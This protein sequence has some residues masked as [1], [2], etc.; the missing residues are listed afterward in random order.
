MHF[1]HRIINT[2][3]LKMSSK[4]FY[5]SN[6][7]LYISSYKKSNIRTLAEH[8]I[9]DVTE[10]N[11]Y[12]HKS[13]QLRLQTL[14]YILVCMLSS[15][16]IKKI[17][18]A[19]ATAFVADVVFSGMMRNSRVMCFTYFYRAHVSYIYSNSVS[20]YN[21]YGL[22]LCHYIIDI[23]LCKFFIFY[24]NGLGSL[25]VKRSIFTVLRSPHTDKKSREQFDRRTH[26]KLYM[27]PTMLS[28]FYSFLC[29]KHY[30]F[31]LCTI[32]HETNKLCDE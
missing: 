17:E 23:E 14:R 16:Q 19:K 30:I 24:K 20:L 10:L 12:V 9:R 26:R 27:F 15:S 13:L 21:M 8:C 32:V 18:I 5:K 3:I 1:F 6:D 22:F 31:L 28:E 2:L 4:L 25:P 7:R 29:E 11:I